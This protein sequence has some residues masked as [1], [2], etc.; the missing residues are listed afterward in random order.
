MNQT[1]SFCFIFYSNQLCDP[2]Q[3]GKFRPNLTNLVQMNTPRV[4]MQDTKKAFRKLHKTGDLQ[5]AASAL[6]NLKGVGPAMASGE[7]RFK[8]DSLSSVV[9]L[10]NIK[11]SGAKQAY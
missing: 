6:C 8:K 5:G 2:L 4:V 7:Q 9:L 10:K 1:A 3:R 11:Y